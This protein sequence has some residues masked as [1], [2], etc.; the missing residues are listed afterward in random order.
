MT[1]SL[2]LSSLAA[3]ALAFTLA[4]CDEQQASDTSAV[5]LQQQGAMPADSGSSAPALPESSEP[6]ALEPQTTD[7]ESMGSDTMEPGTTEPGAMAPNTEQPE[8][9]QPGGNQ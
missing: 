7:P 4:A 6:Q 2:L 3:A 5:P 8:T 1:K 9:L